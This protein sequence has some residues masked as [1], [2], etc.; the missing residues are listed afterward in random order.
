MGVVGL[1]EEA[2]GQDDSELA[3][4]ACKAG[5]DGVR[6]RRARQREEA[7]ELVLAEIGRLEQLLEQNDLCPLVR[8]AACELLCL[9]EVAGGIGAA[10][11]LQR[12]EGQ[13]AQEGLPMCWIESRWIE[14]LPL[15]REAARLPGRRRRVS[16]KQPSP[17]RNLGRWGIA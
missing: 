5:E 9:V 11:E 3:S 8:S 10:G 12:G 2:D 1:L 14:S 4:E 16:L 13:F 17:T 15:C 6:R 7:G